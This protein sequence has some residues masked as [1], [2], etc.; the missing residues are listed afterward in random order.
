MK[1]I[2]PAAVPTQLRERKQ[3]VLWKL[4]PQKTGPAKKLPFQVNGQIA[5]ADDQNT[6]N[7]F[8]AVTRRLPG[9]TGIGYEFSEDD[10]F[11][12]IDL[13]GC[14]NPE[15]GAVA[16]WAR[17]IVL[18]L[19]TYAEVS[20]TETG[21]KLFCIGHSPF[22][23]GRKIEVNEASVCDKKPALE[24][25]D[26]GR[27]FAVTGWRLKGQQSEPQERQSQIDELCAKWFPDTVPTTPAA[28][29]DFRSVPAIIDRAKRYLTRV[30]VAVSGS[31][32]SKVTFNAACVL[33]CG[34]NLTIDEAMSAIQD[35]NARCTPPWTER[36]LLHKMKDAAKQPG[37]RGY[38]RNTSPER[39]QA[40]SVPEY[41]EAPP[42]HEP[43]LTTLSGAA[44]LYIDRM[45]AGKVAL[46]ETGIGEV[47]YA[48]GGGLEFGE[49]VIVAARPSHGK[50]AYALQCVHHW[51]K[52]GMPCLIISEEMAAL[53]LG[54]RT[55]QFVSDV[56]EEHWHTSTTQL[57][58]EMSDYKS[59]RAEAIVA[60][61]CGTTEEAIR[62]IEAAA[63]EHKIR[64]AVVDYAQILKAKGKSQYEE[65]TATSIAMKQLAAKLN[66][67]VMILAQINRDIEDRKKFVPMMSDLKNSGQLEQDAD[68]IMFLVWPHKIDPTRPAHEYQVF[69]SKNRN[70]AI[71]ERLVECRFMPSRQKIL[72]PKASDK[73]NHVKEFV[74]YNEPK[75]ADDFI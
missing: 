25:Y 34:F 65:V 17:Q 52:N 61:S 4:I 28:K 26:W 37:E 58:N 31:N 42:K 62:Q 66:I 33:V 36:E 74:D 21:I 10:P 35:W 45:K 13:D 2:N 72:E 59:I 46:I 57:E 15:T 32:G 3:W 75:T 1:L 54:K 49:M 11:V 44:Q 27:F 55:L 39:W 60:E 47:D 63:A 6:W 71:N 29:H 5:S 38:L 12:G 51:T 18:G 16:E 9:H 20:P 53:A 7:T 22:E 73:K 14:R 23:S 48:L 56:P 30:P 69:V 68:V 8:D 40:V 64:A 24:I 41:Q 43:R 50:S 19:D 70:R 67:V